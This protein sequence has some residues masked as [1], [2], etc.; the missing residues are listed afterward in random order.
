MSA[1]SPMGDTRMRFNFFV[2]ELTKKTGQTTFEGAEGGSCDETTAK[3]GH[4][5]FRG[6]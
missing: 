6:R 1:L 2:A 4:H 3:K 5:L